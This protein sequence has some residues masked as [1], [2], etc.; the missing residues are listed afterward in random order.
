MSNPFEDQ[1]PV[2]KSMTDLFMACAER[3]IEK[4]E[5]DPNW[6]RWQ[7]AEIAAQQT[8]KKN[9]ARRTYQQ[10]LHD[11]AELGDDIKYQYFFK[12]IRPDRY[13]KHHPS[14]ECLVKICNNL[15]LAGLDRYEIFM[16]A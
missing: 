7:I 5:Q 3:L 11:D 2:Q 6:Y 12:I 9:P 13:P 16:G 4:R 1:P 14:R 15:F 10:I 8:N